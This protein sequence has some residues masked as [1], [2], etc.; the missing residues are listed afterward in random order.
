MRTLLFSGVLLAPAMAQAQ[1]QEHVHDVPATAA[2][3]AHQQAAPAAAPA[4]TTGL[5]DHH[6]QLHGGMVNS[7]LMADRLEFTGHD[8]PDLL[9]WELQGWLGTDEHK[10]WLKS[11][12][13]RDR[14][15]GETEEAELHLLYSRAVAPYWDVQAGLRHDDGEAGTVSYATVGLLGLAPYWFETDAALFLSETGKWSARLE[16]EYELRFTQRLILQPRLELNY[17]FTDDSA[18][19]IL[20]G[21]NDNSLGLRLRYEFLREVA[22]YLGVEWWQARDGSGAALQRAGSDR[23]EARIVAGLRLW[24]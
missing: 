21:F 13:E 22:P 15:A 11:E 12:G 17:G 4:L 10:L 20:Q 6:Q 9:Q 23:S 14:D 16:V 1:E 24:Y 18:T 8:D 19:A 3:T 7:L 5:H 2:A